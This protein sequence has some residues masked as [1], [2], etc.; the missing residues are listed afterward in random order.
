MSAIITE[1]FRQHN[2][3]NF[4]ESFSE[5]AAN[6]YYLMIGKATPFTS[7]TTGGS[8]PAPPTP[9]DDVSNEFYTWD[10]TIALKNISSTD[11]SYALP[12][13]DWANSTTY[14]MYDDNINSSNAA[15]SGATNLY[16]ST[17]FFRTSENRVYKVLDNNGGTAYS[18]SEPTSESTSLF[19]L[20]GYV[21]K[22]MYSISASDQTKY[23]TADFM[24]VANDRK[25]ANNCWFWLYQR[26]L[27]CGSI[28]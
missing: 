5:A 23:L 11:V 13:R 24:P 9:T 10:S 7:A 15:T 8:D 14:D 21:L 18:G 28:W 1:K 2:A 22:Y 27:L 19:S 20:G 12:R 25:F 4:F 6:V 26:N 16:Q 17:F 3:G